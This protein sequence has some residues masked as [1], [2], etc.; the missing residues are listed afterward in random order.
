MNWFK[1]AR[2]LQ[3]PSHLRGKGSKRSEFAMKNWIKPAYVLLHNVEP[4]LKVTAI[5]N[6]IIVYMLMSGKE[7]I[8]RPVHHILRLE[9]KVNCKCTFFGEIINHECLGIF[10][11]RSGDAWQCHYKGVARS[12][13]L[14]NNPLLFMVAIC[15][16]DV[17]PRP[18]RQSKLVFSV[19][20]G[21]LGERDYSPVKLPFSLPP[22]PE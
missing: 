6:I 18:D 3:G 15:P 14:T 17:L 1:S 4:K 7:M 10:L 2:I 22:S 11:H 16:F 9:F 21:G 12:F 20:G 13:K 5:L 19:Q 8:C